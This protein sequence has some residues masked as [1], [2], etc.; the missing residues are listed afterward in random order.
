MPFVNLPG[1]SGSRFLPRRI[2]VRRR[3]V[4]LAA[5]YSALAVP[6]CSDATPTIQTLSDSHGA[7]YLVNNGSLQFQLYTT[8]ALAGKITS[9]IYSGQQMV[10]SKDIYY[11]IQ[12]SPNI[13]LGAGENYSVRTGSNYAIISAE[14]P[15][16]TTE[17]LD[18]TWNWIL[19]DGQSGFSTYLTYDHTT[20]MPDYASSENRLG[21]EFFND[22]LFHYSSITNNFWGYQAAGD[23][24]RDQGRFIT[25]ETSD[26][27]GIP[28][29]YT[30]NYETKYD[31][32]STYQQSGGVTGVFGAPNDTT[33]TKP[34]LANDFGA[35]AIE[36]YRTYQ[37]WNAGPTHPQTPVADG[38]SLIPS[39]PG[40]HFGGPDLTYS[41]N[42]SQ[43]FGPIF[44][45]FNQGPN[46]TALRADATQYTSNNPSDPHDLST[47]YDTLN[48]H[49]YT[50]AAGLGT[51]TGDMRITDGSNMSARRFDRP[52]KP[53]LIHTG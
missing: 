42:M 35:W 37:N 22:N 13:F 4:L 26:M 7:Y 41:G 45:Y 18:V 16:T 51:V 52:L 17:P 27:R 3:S 28:S 10:G 50:T 34:L 47:F 25:A 53:R 6:I 38:A 44:T 32:R 9:I 43:S 24:D 2:K 11:D 29:E 30:K 46:I 8:G 20:A 23:A 48:L 14:H 49:D 5:A 40:S 33:S 19:Q 36:N 39:P 21:A 12:G 31:W 15:A 1:R